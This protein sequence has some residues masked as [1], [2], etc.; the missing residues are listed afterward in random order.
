MFRDSLGVR[1]EGNLALYQRVPHFKL[2]PLWNIKFRVIWTGIFGRQH[3]CP[4]KKQFVVQAVAQMLNECSKISDAHLKKLD[5]LSSEVKTNPW[6]E[7]VWLLDIDCLPSFANLCVWNKSWT[8][9]GSGRINWTLPLQ[10]KLM[11]YRMKTIE[12]G[13]QGW[14]DDRLRR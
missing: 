14:P 6:M 9:A 5:L 4:W 13:I 3:T 11:Q 2:W 10:Q 8:T 7:T 1:F 12:V